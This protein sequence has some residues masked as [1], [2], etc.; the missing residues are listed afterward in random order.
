MKTNNTTI[1][2]VETGILLIF[3]PLIVTGALSLIYGI[4]TGA[5]NTGLLQ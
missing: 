3:V 4:I 1:E 2:N 5:I